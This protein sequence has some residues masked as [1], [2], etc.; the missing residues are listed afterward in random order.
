MSLLSHIC[1]QHAANTCEF[2]MC[3][4]VIVMWNTW[5]WDVKQSWTLFGLDCWGSICVRMSSHFSC[6]L[7]L[8][9]LLSSSI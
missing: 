2:A 1:G 3:M 8:R 6:S 9:L 4:H 7:S 5:R